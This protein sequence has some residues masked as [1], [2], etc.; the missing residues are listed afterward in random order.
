VVLS[1]NKKISQ[2]AIESI[3]T[4]EGEF[5]V[6]NLKVENYKNSFAEGVLSHFYFQ[7]D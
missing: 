6:Y 4:I 2:A 1:D 3:Q 5:T 7:P